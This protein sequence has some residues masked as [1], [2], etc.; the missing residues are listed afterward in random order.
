M[1]YMNEEENEAGDA[2][3]EDIGFAMRDLQ[4]GILADR[5]ATTVLMEK[6]L[7][8]SHRWN[9]DQQAVANDIKAGFRYWFGL[10]PE[11]YADSVRA[12]GA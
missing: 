2:Y 4:D 6:A 10:D 12:P 7:P 8:L 11:D 1:A 5:E 3:A 9:K